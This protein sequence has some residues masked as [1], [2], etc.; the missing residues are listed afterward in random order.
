LGYSFL[1]GLLG[2]EYKIQEENQWEV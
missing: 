2:K 1:S